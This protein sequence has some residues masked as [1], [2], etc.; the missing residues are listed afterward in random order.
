MEEKGIVMKNFLLSPVT[1]AVT[2]MFALMI[3]FGSADLFAQTPPATNAVTY[4]DLVT[5]SEIFTTI[6]SAVGPMVAGAI[7]LGLAI[8]GARYVF[9]IIKS[10]GR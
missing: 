3:V 5:W 6:R 10:M 9:G 7:S 4:S 1:Y 2:G 8:W